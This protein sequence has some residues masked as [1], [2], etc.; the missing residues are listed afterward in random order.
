MRKLMLLATS[1]AALTACGPKAEKAADTTRASDTA[2][3]APAP[4][5]AAATT[6]A[7]APAVT[8]AQIAA[9]VVA[10]N[11]V[12][13][14]A[15]KLAESKG[16]NPKVKSFGKQMVTDHTGVNKA[17]T[18]LVTKLGVTPEPN[19]TS[20]SLTA[21]GEQNLADLQG[22]SGADFDRAYIDHEVKYHQSVIDAIDATLIPNA[23]NAELKNML[24]TT[25]PAFVAHLRMAQ[26]VQSSLKP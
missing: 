15:G 16:T 9:I 21:G 6:P 19:E 3:M 11:D 14:A 22:K 20:R 18:A 25:R 8:D 26:G 5:P 23:K 7:A 1:A 2:M 24:V 4:A 12:D 10:A 17:A 13:I